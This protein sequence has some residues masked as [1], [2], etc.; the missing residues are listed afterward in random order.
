VYA[1]FDK[2]VEDSDFPYG[3][4]RAKLGVHDE[5]ALPRFAEELNQLQSP[6]FASWFTL[7]SHAPYD[8]PV[9]YHLDINGT[10]VGYIN[11]VH[12]TDSCLGAF[13]DN[14]RKA[15]WYNNTLFV[16]MSDHG[17]SSPKKTPYY[18]PD[19]RKIPLLLYG[20]VLKE[21]YRG[22]E[23]HKIG[24]QCDLVATLLAQLQL[25]YG[26]YRWSKDLLNPLAPEFAYFVFDD[27]LGYIDRE[28]YFSFHHEL[29]MYMDQSYTDSTAMEATRKKGKSHLQ[30]VFEEFLNL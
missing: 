18:H 13:F 27:G 10:E 9:A 25:D 6:F 3:T 30:V 20:N 2:L 8:I 12:Y 21:E 1:G 17:H 23:N 4:P 19:Y 29:N 22:V 11:S 14:I 28:N 7:S 15:P 24:S 5:Y 26:A 16:V